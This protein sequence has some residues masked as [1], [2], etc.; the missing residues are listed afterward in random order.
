VWVENRR[1]TAVDEGLLNKQERLW[2][3]SDL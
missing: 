2:Q 3:D 1:N